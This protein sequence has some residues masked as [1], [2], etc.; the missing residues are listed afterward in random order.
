VL[1]SG[2]DPGMPAGQSFS[3]LD[4]ET[5]AALI[6]WYGTEAADVA[7]YCAAH[8]LTRRLAEGCAVLA[9]EIGYAVAHGAAVRLADVVLRRTRLGGIGHPGAAAVS[10]AADLMTSAHDWSPAERASEIAHVE[11]RYPRVTTAR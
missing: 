3:G 4:A 1:P 7:A 10:A 2:G 6:D 5:S 9:G 8:G 11:T